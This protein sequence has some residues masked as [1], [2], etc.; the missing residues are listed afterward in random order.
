LEAKPVLAG[1]LWIP[2]EG[3][4]AQALRD[5]FT[6]DYWKLGAKESIPVQGF[7]EAEGYVGVPRQAGLQLIANQ[8]FEDRRST[9]HAVRFP[10]KPALRPNQVP[11]VRD[12][13]EA[14]R[15]QY[16]DFMGYAATGKGKTVCALAVAE[17][18]GR[19]T[20]ALVD[21][22]RLMRQWIE[23]AQEHLG[24]DTDISVDDIMA[25]RGRD[26]GI[27]QGPLCN[28]EDKKLVVAMV[29]SVAQRQYD[30]ALYDYFGT[31]VLDEV[32]IAGAPVFSRVLML[33]SALV[34]FGVSATPDRPDILK[35]LLL[36]NLGTVEAQ[37]TER[38]KKS[39]VYYVESEAVVSWYANKAKM[40]GRYLSELSEDPARNLL[41]C[42]AA[43]WL[44]ESGRVVLV[45]GDRIEQLCNLMALCRAMG[46]PGEA[47]GLYAR[48]RYEWRF[49]KN[50]TPLRNPPGWERGTAFTPVE[51]APIAKRNRPQDLQQVFD[52]A[53]VIFATNQMF[54]KGVDMPRLSGGIDCTPNSQAVQVHGRILRTDSSK[55]LPI[56]V[57]IRDPWSYRAEHQFAARLEDYVASNA[58]V[59]LWNLDK[60]VR[61]QDVPSLL[62]EIRDRIVVLKRQR[63]TT[64]L[65]GS[66]TVVTPDTLSGSARPHGRPT[67]RITRSRQASS[68]MAS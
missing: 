38:H 23:R 1:C 16:P 44:Y 13:L 7:V 2:V 39:R 10:R 17:E 21:Q 60:G 14:A 26:I 43:K 64:K 63:I 67:G 61:Q 32:H 51:F 15:G 34:R 65:D 22:D 19:T 56:W 5:R 48:F 11:F 42:R 31:V 40:T 12:M 41:I 20:L 45:V 53:S 50:P 58:E 55:K 37:L 35:K 24:L 8:E 66:Y 62:V 9:G 30:E 59:Y 4:R 46:M 6:L 68:P 18:L 49:E 29:Q 47:L 28:F 54:K 3:R 57:T 25:G 52:N 27:V 33:F 36:W